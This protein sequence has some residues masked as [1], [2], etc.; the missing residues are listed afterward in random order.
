LRKKYSLY[1]EA[2]SGVS[3]QYVVVYDWLGLKLKYRTVNLSRE[4]AQA[5]TEGGYRRMTA[6]PDDR[7]GSAQLL[8]WNWR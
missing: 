2:F 5:I 3:K 4:T 6:V 8:I 1:A 7:V